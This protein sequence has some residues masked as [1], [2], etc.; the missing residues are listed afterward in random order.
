MKIK[1]KRIRFN[2]NKLR[3]SLLFGLAF[4]ICLSLGLKATAANYTEIKGYPAYV[5]V[6]VK[7]GDS[8][9]EL[10]ET[11]YKGNEDI[12]KII[13]RIKELNKLENAKII[14]GQIIKIPQA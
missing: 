12:R 14:P 9:W 8:I 11:Y 10:T 6:I 4:I 1:G 2:L 7:S 5:E 3:A 13:F